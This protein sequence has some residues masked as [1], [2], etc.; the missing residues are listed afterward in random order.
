MTELR[1]LQ[2][3]MIRDSPVMDYNVTTQDQRLSLVDVAEVKNDSLEFLR[4]GKK[5]IWPSQFNLL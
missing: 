4:G 1:V 5:D 3:R 2:Y